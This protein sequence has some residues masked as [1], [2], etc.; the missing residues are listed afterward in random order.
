[1]ANKLNTYFSSV[2][3][4]EQLNNIPQL[5]INVRNTLDT[6]NLILEDVQEKLN[7]RNM[8]KSAGPELLHPRALQT[9]E[10]MLCGPL[11]EPHF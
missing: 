7:H 3:T 6:F 8:C 4:P 1:M 9:F 10:G 11:A 2:F 5:P